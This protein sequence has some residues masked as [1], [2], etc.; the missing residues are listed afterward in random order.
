M[1]FGDTGTMISAHVTDDVLKRQL[2]KQSQELWR[3]IR[4]DYSKELEISSTGILVHNSCISHCIRYA[5]GISQAIK[6]YIKIGYDV[7]TG[8]DIESAIKDIAGTKIANL[9]ANQNN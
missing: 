2:L 9:N 8:D 5:F 3:Y 6:R 4:S 7:N 1:V